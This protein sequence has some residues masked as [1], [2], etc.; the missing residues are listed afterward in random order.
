MGAPQATKTRDKK[1]NSV[2]VGYIMTD[3]EDGFKIKEGREEHR[4]L[5]RHQEKIEKKS[6]GA[7]QA[8]NVHCGFILLENK[9][10]Y[11]SFSPKNSAVRVNG[12]F[13]D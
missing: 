8:K 2:E 10:G 12:D 9:K 5:Q 6:G 7:R 11:C 1:L 13:R 3:V 4:A